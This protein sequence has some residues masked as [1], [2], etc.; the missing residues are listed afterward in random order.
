[1]RGFKRLASVVLSRF[2]GFFSL[3][4]PMLARLDIQ[5]GIIA[6]TTAVSVEAFLLS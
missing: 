3:S 2:C 6:Q 4:L 5:W 1:M